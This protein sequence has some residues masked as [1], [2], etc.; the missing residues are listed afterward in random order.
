MGF[1]RR[2]FEDIFCRREL[3]PKGECFYKYVFDQYDK[4]EV[5][6]IEDYEDTILEIRDL[7]EEHLGFEATKEDAIDFLVAYYYETY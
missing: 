7:M 5:D 4:K 3:T 2:L 6:E 1:I